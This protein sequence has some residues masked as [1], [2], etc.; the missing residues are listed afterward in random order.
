MTVLRTKSS[1]TIHVWTMVMNTVNAFFWCIY[2][3][4]IQ[5][6]Y[7]LIPNGLGFLF[8]ILQMVM[9][10][11]YR[12]SDITDGDGIAQFLDEDG[13]SKAGDSQ[14]DII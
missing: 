7:I 2:S 1:S 10:M 12:Q 3:L 13:N 14:M 6:Y 5:D 8:G 11:I 4:A 9:Y